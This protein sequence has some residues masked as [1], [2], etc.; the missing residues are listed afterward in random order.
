MRP[1]TSHDA[2]GRPWT[3]VGLSRAVVLGGGQT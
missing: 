3:S 1:G 2:E